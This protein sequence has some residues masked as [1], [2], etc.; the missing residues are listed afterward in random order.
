M[1]TRTI[2]SDQT[3]VTFNG[4]GSSGGDYYAA[5]TPV[6]MILADLA[7][8]CK[9]SAKNST[10]K[11]KRHRITYAKLVSDKTG[12]KLREWSEQDLAKLTLTTNA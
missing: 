10:D 5:G 2:H 3:L 11:L 1:N 12:R 9:H 6:A 8:F 7:S 4:F